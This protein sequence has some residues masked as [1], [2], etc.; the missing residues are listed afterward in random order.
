[1]AETELLEIIETTS[2][3]VARFHMLARQEKLA[4]IK[5]CPRLHIANY[6]ADLRA[7]VD[8]EMAKRQHKYR[9]DKKRNKK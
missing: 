9:D 8:L 3:T 4:E 1:M 7:E 6:F 2:E 5:E